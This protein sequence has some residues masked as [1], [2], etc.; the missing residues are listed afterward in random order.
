VINTLPTLTPTHWKLWIYTNYDCNLRCSYCCANS[1]PTAPRRAIGLANVKQLVDEATDLGFAHL[2][3]TGGE[4]FLLDDIY[5]MLSYASAKLP[6]TILTNAMLFKQKIPGTNKTRLDKLSEIPHDDDQLIIQVSLDGA[7]P[8]QHD[9]YRGEGTWAKTVEGI[10]LLQSNG[11]RVR[12]G[13]TE[14]PANTAHMDK[15]CA[16][17]DSLGIPHSDHIVRPLARRGFSEDGLELNTTNLAAELTANVDGLFWHPLST[18]PDML[19]SQ[20]LFPLSHAV[21]QVEARLAETACTD[22]PKSSFTCG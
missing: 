15:I 21:K 18:D 9:P 1:S 16:F 11:F 13:T 19:V 17:H 10:K 14:T 3:F 2:Y 4:P 7:I 8:E 22:T 5:D 20:S 6:T 12:L